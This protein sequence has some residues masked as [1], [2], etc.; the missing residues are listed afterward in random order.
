M[1][2]S[3]FM[4]TYYEYVIFFFLC[5]FLSSFVLLLCIIFA[6]QNLYYEKNT[7]YECGFNPFSDARDPFNIK[8]FLIAILFILFDIELL[9]FFP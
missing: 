4:Y 3:Y 5:C 8:F 7:G 6:N 9:F 1:F 2:F